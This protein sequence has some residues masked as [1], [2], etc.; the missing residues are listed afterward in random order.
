[1]NDTRYSRNEALFGAEGQ[2][3]LSRTK[4]AIVG[5]GGLGSHVVQ[6]LAYL[7]VLEFVLVDDDIVTDSSLNRL[8][9][10][11]DFDVNVQTPK[12]ASAERLIKLVVPDA[13]IRTLVSKVESVEV[14]PAI[15]NVDVVFGC[16]DN[17]LPR[18]ALTEVCARLAK[19][20]FDLAT[21]TETRPEPTFG[22]R[23]A[24]CNGTGCLSCLDML[25]Q[26][27]MARDSMSP[28]HKAA[29]DRTYGIPADALDQTGPAVVSVN[30][31]VASLAVTEFM[32][33]VTGI[34]TP[35]PVLN[36]YGEKRLI[37]RSLDAA[38][39]N[40]LYCT[41]LWGQGFENAI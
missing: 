12:V 24:F 15:A 30:G 3:K 7:G 1:M 27:E 13:R 11:Y 35:V 23:I 10:A 40:C 5:L 39:P 33:F 4:V 31:A 16:L 34:A 25:D 37:R 41:E 17:D 36:Y 29:R 32:G 18:L 26:D 6:Q 21:D 2:E 19:P 20:Y 8:I 28:E 38:R 22:G 14:G 9:G